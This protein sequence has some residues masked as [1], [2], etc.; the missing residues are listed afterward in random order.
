MTWQTKVYK[1]N[2]TLGWGICIPPFSGVDISPAG[3]I[4]PHH[5]PCPKKQELTLNRVSKPI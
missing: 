4:Y 3:G 5:S 2:Y 1:T